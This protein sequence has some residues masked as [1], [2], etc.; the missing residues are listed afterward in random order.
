[1]S[2]CE[3]RASSAQG[4]APVAQESRIARIIRPSKSKATS[5]VLGRETLAEVHTDLNR[6]TVPSWVSPVPKNAGTKQ[7]GKLS[8]DQWRT[9]CTIHL[10]ITLIR[11]W[12]QK[13]E[14]SRERRML[15]NFLDLVT[16]VEVAGMLI[17]SDA[18]IAEYQRAILR[19]LRT[20]QDLYKDAPFKPNHHLAIHVGDTILPQFGP[21]HPIRAFHTERN[22]FTLQMENTNMKFG[23]QQ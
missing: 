21:L 14:G 8:A 2:L 5:A 18:H 1:M 16:A 19:Y 13:N 12:G 10:P 6:T 23:E 17:T 15:D 3:Q 20:M 4:S 22:N 9:L 11:I 7:H